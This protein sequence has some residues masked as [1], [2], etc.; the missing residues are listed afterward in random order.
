MK[1]ETLYYGI[2]LPILLCVIGIIASIYADEIKKGMT[3]LNINQRF[4]SV[5]FINYICILLLLIAFTIFIIVY[6]K[7]KLYSLTDNATKSITHFTTEMNKKI[8]A[9]M[10][11]FNGS[12]TKQYGYFRNEDAEMREE[13]RKRDNQIDAKVAEFKT[14]LQKKL[15]ALKIFRDREMIH[16]A[17]YYN[18]QLATFEIRLKM[19]QDKLKEHNIEISLADRVEKTDP[20]DIRNE[21]ESE[22][23]WNQQMLAYN[24]AFKDWNI[25]NYGTEDNITIYKGKDYKV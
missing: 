20:N 9:S 18:A 8:Y 4:T 22:K 5:G 24:E 21:K 15:L 1:K 6:I 2:L 10:S 17:D 19:L 16:L 13:F 3:N 25:G 12:L 14:D 23:A 7:R 11:D